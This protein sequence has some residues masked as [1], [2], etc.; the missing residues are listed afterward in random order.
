MV[1]NSPTGTRPANTSDSV[2]RLMPERTARTR[3]SPSPAAR[4][5][6]LADL[7]SAGLDEPE[8]ECLLDHAGSSSRTVELTPCHRSWQGWYT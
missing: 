4:Q 3:T 8:R 5:G 7:S 6:D 2:P 1:S